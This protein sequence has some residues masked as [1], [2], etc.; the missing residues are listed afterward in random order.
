M[1]KGNTGKSSPL[2]TGDFSDPVVSWK[3]GTQ[4]T[5]EQLAAYLWQDVI[6]RRM[7]GDWLGDAVSCNTADRKGTITDLAAK[8]VTHLLNA[9][10]DR[11]VLC[12]LA[13]SI[14]FESINRTFMTLEE[15]GIKWPGGKP[16]WESLVMA[17][18]Q[19]AT[20]DKKGRCGGWPPK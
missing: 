9:G 19:N 12:H 10:V 14:C 13:R 16:D 2:P 3:K 17:L 4:P 1:L 6:D 20:I 5:P 15:T 7:T 11:N 18:V 8:A